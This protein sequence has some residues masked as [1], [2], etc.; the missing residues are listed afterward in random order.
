[1]LL[2]QSQ[3]LSPP[4]PAPPTEAAPTADPGATEP[5]AQDSAPAEDQSDIVIVGRRPSPDD[6]LEDLNSES[7]KG[8]QSVDESFVAPIAFAYEDVMPRPV[9]KGLSNFL[10]NLGEP[11]VALNFL[12]QLKPGKAAETLGRFAINTTLGAGGLVDVAKRKPFN[13]PRRQ[14]GFA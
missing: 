13:L 2:A 9:R 14:N 11:I 5:Q 3:S 12:L 6:P 8:A 4:Q 7:F 1:L 10:N